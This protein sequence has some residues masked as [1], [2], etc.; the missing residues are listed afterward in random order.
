MTRS[1]LHQVINWSGDHPMNDLQFV[2]GSPCW[3]PRQHTDKPPGCL[4]SLHTQNHSVLYKC[5]PMQTL[6][7]VSSERILI[8]LTSSISTPNSI[9]LLYNTI[10]NH[11]LSQSLRIADVPSHCTP[12]FFC[13]I[14]QIKKIW[15]VVD[16][17]CQNPHWWSPVIS[18]MYGLRLER[19]ILDNILYEVYNNDVPQ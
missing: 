6:V 7:Q 5:L 11:R 14:W 3:V 17:L 16:L 2:G 10:L 8:S 12:I 19:K 1:I 9:K 4:I 15:S 13:S 18:S